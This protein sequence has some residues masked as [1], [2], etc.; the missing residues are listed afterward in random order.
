MLSVVALCKFTR[1]AAPT[2]V[3]RLL[4]CYQ[5]LPTPRTLQQWLSFA[6]IQIDKRSAPTFNTTN[7]NMYT[8]TGINCS[9]DHACFP[10]EAFSG[11]TPTS[12]Y[13]Y[14]HVFSLL[15]LLR[16]ARK[17]DATVSSTAKVSSRTPRMYHHP[18]EIAQASTHR[19]C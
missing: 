10:Q 7:T 14:T 11:N 19:R 4:L 5:K 13:P 3:R 1:R 18:T 12:I 16:V 15:R 9:R 6:K 17:H 2:H 8:R